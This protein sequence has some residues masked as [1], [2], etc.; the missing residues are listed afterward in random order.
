MQI[1]GLGKG[2]TE[3]L[4]N[5]LNGKVDNVS[6]ITA[7]SATAYM[8]FCGDRN[9]NLKRIPS[10]SFSSGTENL[11]EINNIHSQLSNW[12]TKFRGIS[13]R[14]FQNYLNWFTYLFIMLKKFEIDDLRHLNSGDLR[15]LKQMHLK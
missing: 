4:E 2:T 3:M 13:T 1:G 15:V 11:A 7:D 10:G 9:I 14:H 5:C 12:I 8:K 6:S